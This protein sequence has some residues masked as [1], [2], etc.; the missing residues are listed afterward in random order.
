MFRAY[1]DMMKK[2]YKLVHN[3]FPL[4]TSIQPASISNIKM[5]LKLRGLEIVAFE[6]VYL[7]SMFMS[8]TVSLARD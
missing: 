3:P 2:H 8:G 1:T 6:F 7:Y 4:S 5:V